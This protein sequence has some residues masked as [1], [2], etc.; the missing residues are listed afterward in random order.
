MADDVALTQATTI[1]RCVARL[2]EEY[3]G[4]GHELA[5][6]QR[7]QDA[8][9]LNLLRACETGSAPPASATTPCT[10]TTS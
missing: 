4:D 9:V 2:R 8:L 1:E 7:H 3:A 10:A 5:V 6:H